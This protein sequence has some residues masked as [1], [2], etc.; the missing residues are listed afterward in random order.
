MQPISRRPRSLLGSLKWYVY[1]CTTCIYLYS[2]L[3]CY[4]SIQPELVPC[5]I[6]EFD[7]LISKPKLA[8]EDKFQDHI[9][10]RSRWE[11]EGL[12]DA[13]LRTVPQG[14]VVQLERKG[15][16]RVDQAYGGANKPIVL[17]AIPDGKQKK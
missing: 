9:N 8:E 2:K 1:E 13:C 17:F 6:V 4:E 11:S 10:P 15:F 7:H 12:G 16:F 3:Y 14:T 5:K